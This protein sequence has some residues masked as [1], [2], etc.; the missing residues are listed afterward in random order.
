[1]YHVAHGSVTGLPTAGS[2]LA[3]PWGLRSLLMSC[4]WVTDRRPG[5][6]RVRNEAL[7]AWTELRGPGKH[8]AQPADPARADSL[9]VGVRSGSLS[10]GRAPR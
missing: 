9:L 7:C 4:R 10:E 3:W 2:A 5:Q 1:M 6:S 8:L